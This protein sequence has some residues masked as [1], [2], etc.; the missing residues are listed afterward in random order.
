M[1]RSYPPAPIPTLEERL[2]HAPTDYERKMIQF[3][4]GLSIRSI[5]EESG[6]LDRALE[7]VAS[8][9]KEFKFSEENQAAFDVGVQIGLE[10]TPAVLTDFPPSGIPAPNQEQ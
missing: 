10:L 9:S 8:H 2:G 7:R 4:V 3:G 5:L 1:G 6:D